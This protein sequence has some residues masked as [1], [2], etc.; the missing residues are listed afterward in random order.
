[1]ENREWTFL[2]IS[3]VG[4]PVRQ[5]SVSTRVVSYAASFISALTTSV[6]ALLVMAA[7]E[8]SARYEIRGLRSEKILLS[9]EVLDLQ[10]K[11]SEI[12]GLVDGLVENDERY[13]LLA[14]LGP[15]H[16]EIYEVGVGGPGTLAPISSLLWDTD[17]TTAKTIGAIDHDLSALK[18]RAEL[19][20]TSLT[21]ATGR[22]ETNR[23]LLES[24]PSIIPAAGLLSSGFSQARL[25]PLSN[26]ALPHP[27]IDLSA[28]GG[29]PIFSA[30][31]GVVSYAGWKPGYGYTVEVDHGFGYMT[32][33]AHASKLFVI[34]GQKVKRGESLAEVGK[35]GMATADHLH[36][37]VW[38]GGEAKNPLNYI[39]NG[40]IP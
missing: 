19:L 14:G 34:R 15:I 20:S 9:Q 35:T 21:E 5:Y 40:V 12:E 2:C 3:G 1:M 29:T 17:P 37:E 10:E 4:N 26:E 18:R 24:T 25:H 27:G 11:A 16:E 30:A 8:G 39:L 13:R 33:Y 7:V 38:V 32:R 28:V 6:V 36:Y 31:K 22:L 23:A